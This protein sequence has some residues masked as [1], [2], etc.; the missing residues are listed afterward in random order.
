MDI[1]IHQAFFAF[2][3]YFSMARGILQNQRVFTGLDKLHNFA[4]LKLVGFT[5][6][7]KIQNLLHSI[8]QYATD[9]NR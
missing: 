1:N 6:F 3:A 7:Q 5:R 9:N 4:E 8:E 2:A